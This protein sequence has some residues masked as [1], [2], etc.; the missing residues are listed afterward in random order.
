MIRLTPRKTESDYSFLALELNK[1]SYE[2]QSLA[3]REHSGDTSRFTFTNIATNVKVN[4]NS[5]RFKTPKGVEE[6]RFSE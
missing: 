5:F 2:I 6:V 1:D 3:V 4:N